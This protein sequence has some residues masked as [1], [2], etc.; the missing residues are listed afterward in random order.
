MQ[1]LAF[2][3]VSMAHGI[4]AEAKVG[5]VKLISGACGSVGMT[6]GQSIDLASE[7]QELS[8]EEI[9]HMYSLKTGALIHAA[10]VSA[11]MLADNIPAEEHVALDGFGRDVGIAFQIKDDILDVEGDTDVIGKPAG[12]DEQLNKATYPNLL[13]IEN[14]K[15]RCDELL[16]RGLGRLEIFGERAQPLRWLAEYV[17]SRGN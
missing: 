4:S 8:A 10:I 14:S 5:L 17:V 12:S 11:C 6:G 1:P 3:V 2:E 9:E 13:G 7:G 16:S 15:Q